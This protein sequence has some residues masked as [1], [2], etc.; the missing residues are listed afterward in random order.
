MRQV[1]EQILA[2]SRR[3]YSGQV[4]IWIGGRMNNKVKAAYL[5]RRSRRAGDGQEPSRKPGFFM[6]HMRTK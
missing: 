2:E 6:E 5:A 1:S 3:E 4:G